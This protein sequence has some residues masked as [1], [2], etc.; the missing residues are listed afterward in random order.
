MS[1]VKTITDTVPRAKSVIVKEPHKAQ[2]TKIKQE[3][4]NLES[5]CSL[6]SRMYVSCQS[7]DGD[8][9]DLF[10]HENLS[11]PPSLSNGGKLAPAVNKSDILDCIT[12]SCTNLS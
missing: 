12:P 8:L 2:T 4:Q 10:K 6:F 3:I 7:R 5:D 9:D 1:N 11:Y